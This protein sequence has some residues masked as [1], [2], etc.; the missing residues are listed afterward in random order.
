MSDICSSYRGQEGALDHKERELQVAVGG[1]MWV[2]GTFKNNKD[3]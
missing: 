1:L 2:L 3:S